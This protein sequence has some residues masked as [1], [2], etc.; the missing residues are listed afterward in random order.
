MEKK[1]LRR[2]IVKII[3]LT[4]GTITTYYVGWNAHEICIS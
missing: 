4:I 3:L 1:Q 2:E